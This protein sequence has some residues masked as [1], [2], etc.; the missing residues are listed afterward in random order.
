[1]NT[2]PALG[3]FTNPLIERPGNATVDCTPGCFAAMS[4]SRLITSSVRSNDEASG[5]CAYATTYCLSCVGT[6]PGGTRLN[7]IS[8]ITMRPAY[9]ASATALLP[10]NLPTARPYL[11]EP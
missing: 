5:S 1:M 9:T 11:F 4:D 7:P 6:K 10:I 8:V 2:V 3:L